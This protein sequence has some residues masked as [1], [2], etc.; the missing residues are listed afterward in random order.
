[1][2]PGDLQKLARSWGAS[3]E[4]SSATM[5][6]SGRLAELQ[7]QKRDAAG[8]EDFKE[9]QRIK[10]EIENLEAKAEIVRL[11]SQLE[12]LKTAS[13]KQTQLMEFVFEDAEL[14]VQASAA[15]RLEA[16]RQAASMEELQ[17]KQ[18]ELTAV[19]EEA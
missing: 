1:M 8:R 19:T 2:K 6:P 13:A 16:E 18:A 14:R 12:Q 17:H 9:A 11:K 10:R 15:A 7:A 3:D 4:D 5:A